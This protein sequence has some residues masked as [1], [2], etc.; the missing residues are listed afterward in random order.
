M[1][2]MSRESKTAAMMSD[3]V[4]SYEY[5]FKMM[6]RRLLSGLNWSL[7]RGRV[8]FRGCNKTWYFF[9]GSFIV[10]FM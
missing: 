2:E 9:L 5:P 8:S 4:M 1:V 6:V 3:D 7:F 10:H